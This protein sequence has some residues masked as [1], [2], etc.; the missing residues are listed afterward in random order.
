MYLIINYKYN[1]YIINSRIESIYIKNDS[2]SKEIENKIGDIEYKNTKA[3]KN[4]VLKEE[5]WLK[6]KWENVIYLIEERK[7]EKYTNNP[8]KWTKD[9]IVIIK[10]INI[11][12]SMNILEKWIYLIFK[13]D[14]R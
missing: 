4:K 9:N 8:L 1:E 3:Y 12:D 7:Y 14:I 5:Q 10:D 6:N 13:K 2:I 11:I